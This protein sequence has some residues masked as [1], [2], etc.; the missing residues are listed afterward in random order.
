MGYLS[1][2]LNL[3]GL[4]N[5]LCSENTMHSEFNLFNSYPL[6]GHSLREKKESEP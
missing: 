4:Y 1:D 3:G 2:K 6:D 5:S